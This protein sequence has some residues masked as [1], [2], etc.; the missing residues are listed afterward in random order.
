MIYGN[1]IK[2]ETTFAEIIDAFKK[3]IEAANEKYLIAKDGTSY[4]KEIKGGL[5]KDGNV[6]VIEY[7]NDD[8]NRI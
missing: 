8:K 3:G 2:D 1:R 7:N 4:L 5:G 6:I